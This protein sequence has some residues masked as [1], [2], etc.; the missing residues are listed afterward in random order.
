MKM[1]ARWRRLPRV[2]AR[3]LAL[4][5]F[6]ASVALVFGCGKGDCER[7][8]REVARCKAEAR[9]G[10]PLL[11]EQAPPADAACMKRCA[12]AS[13]RFAACEA[14]KKSCGD[15]LRCIP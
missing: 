7:A 15:L 13:D 4:V 3:S 5:A 6:V 8:C 11:G 12:E 10:Q 9:D 2:I 14:K 1:R